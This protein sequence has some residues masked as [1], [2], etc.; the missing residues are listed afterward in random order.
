ME[1]RQAT[2][3]DGGVGPEAIADFLRRLRSGVEDGLDPLGAAERAAG[4]LPS[5]LRSSVELM[6]RRMRGDYR[7]DEWGFDEQFAEAAFP[8]FEFLYEVWWRVT[9][10][11]IENVPS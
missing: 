1:A 6:A 4:G 10:T 8:I 5:S 2:E 7:E 9:T 3:T 11:G